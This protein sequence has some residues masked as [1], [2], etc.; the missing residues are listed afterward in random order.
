MELYIAPSRPN[1]NPINGRF[2]KG[3]TPHN[4]GRKWD[5]WMSKEAQARLREALK[6]TGRPRMDIGGWNKKAVI[7]VDKDG[8]HAWFESSLAAEKATGVRAR[9]IRH[10]CNKQRGSAGGYRWFHFDSDEWTNYVNNK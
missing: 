1:K 7:M 10:C 6:T 9:N 5:D 2:V 4:K 3:S 8:N